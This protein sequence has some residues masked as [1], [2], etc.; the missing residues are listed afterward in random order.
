MVPTMMHK[1]QMI[2]RNLPGTFALPNPS[3]PATKVVVS[4]MIMMIPLV[5]AAEILATVC[6]LVLTPGS[7]TDERVG[8]ALMIGSVGSVTFMLTGAFGLR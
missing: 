1:L 6:N 3:D 8:K 5:L 2:L 4:I 7:D